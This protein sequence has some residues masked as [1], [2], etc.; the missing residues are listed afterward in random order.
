MSA[1]S[2]ESLATAAAAKS[3]PNAQSASVVVGGDPH[4]LKQTVDSSHLK[5]LLPTVASPS[6]A[7]LP[8]KSTM[9]PASLIDMCRF[10]TSNRQ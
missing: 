3:A 1:D 4:P 9:I 5:L 2:E 7:V 8:P 6:D 10:N